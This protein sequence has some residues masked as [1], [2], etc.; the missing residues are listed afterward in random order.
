MARQDNQAIP[1]IESSPRKEDEERIQSGSDEEI[2][3][4]ADEDEDVFEETE[5]SDEDEEEEE[6]GV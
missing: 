6:G 1:E 3:D 5:E 2:R 4:I